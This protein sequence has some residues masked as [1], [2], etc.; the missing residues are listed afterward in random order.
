MKMSRLVKIPW[1]Q[2]FDAFQ[3]DFQTF[4]TNWLAR[5]WVQAEEVGPVLLSTT[6]TNVQHGLGRQYIGWAVAD[7]DNSAIVFRDATSTA[8]NKLY[9]PLKLDSG[10]ANVKVL[11]W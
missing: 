5:R 4:I 7:I 9:L 8:D 6:T 11:V 1:H 10:T 2:D 3:K